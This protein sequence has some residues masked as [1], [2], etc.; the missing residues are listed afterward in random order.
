M[1][2]LEKIRYR[3]PNRPAMLSLGTTFGLCFVLFACQAQASV[4]TPAG[5]STNPLNLDPLV[6]QAFQR[7]Y[8]LDYDGA[9]TRFEKVQ[10]QNPANPLAVDYVL[11]TVIFR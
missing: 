5:V 9:V 3:I 6:R 1:K 10:E 8:I 11:Y 7:F 4:T 2:F